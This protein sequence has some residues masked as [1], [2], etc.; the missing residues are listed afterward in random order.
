MLQRIQTIY[1]LI[2]TVFYF[3]YWFF[4]LEWYEKGYSIISNIFNDTDY[5][6]NILIVISY[7]PVL[8]SLIC[9]VAIFMFKNRELI[10][11][12]TLKRKLQ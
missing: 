11:T 12:R 5:V 3:I 4:G 1:L 7:I 10:K 2:A 6:Y 8:I 9:L